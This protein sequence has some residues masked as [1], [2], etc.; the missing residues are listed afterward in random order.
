M[1]AT[2]VQVQ[3]EAEPVTKSAAPTVTTSV[4][5]PTA[6]TASSLDWVLEGLS[7]H[8]KKFKTP[9]EYFLA[10]LSDLQRLGVSNLEK[11]RNVLKDLQET[12]LTTLLI[13]PLLSMYDLT[14]ETNSNGHPDIHLHV[15]A[16]WPGLSWKAEAKIIKTLDW[17]CQG[18]IKLVEKFNSGRESD[19]FMVGYCRAPDPHALKAEY[20]AHLEKYRVANFLSWINGPPDDVSGHKSNGSPIRVHH[21]WA[22]CFYET[23][24]GAF[25]RK[26]E[27]L[28]RSAAKPAP[29]KPTAKK[30]VPPPK[31]TR[32]RKTTGKKVAASGSVTSSRRASFAG[33]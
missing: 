24:D 11:N 19:T 33:C 14:T 7:E 20:M 1:T 5:K 30:R 23:D 29:S 6:Q 9:E 22:N 2:T 4:E 13:S 31:N 12:A 17:Y 8:I 27:G 28:R 25:T 26:P 3:V 32:A 10:F 16:R 18:L 15:K 21:L